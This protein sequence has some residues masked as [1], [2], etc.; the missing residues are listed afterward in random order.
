[1]KQVPRGP[2][3]A[4]PLQSRGWQLPCVYLVVLG[5][6]DGAPRVYE[7]PTLEKARE[8]G[9]RLLESDDYEWCTVYLKEKR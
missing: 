4:R 7:E 8:L 1:M 2:V 3:D 9:Y 6:R 5:R